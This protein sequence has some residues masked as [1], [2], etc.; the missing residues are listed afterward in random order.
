MKTKKT[1]VINDREYFIRKSDFTSNESP[2]HVSDKMTGKLSGI[3]SIS[4]ACL[5]N[6]ICKKRMENGN[7]ICAHCFAAALLEK[8]DTV[9]Q[10]M[11]S[12]FYLLQNLLP[13]D[14]LPRFRNVCIVRIES[15]GDVASVNQ[16]KN[17]INICKVNP[18]VRFAAWTKN[19]WIWEAAIDELGKPEN[20][21]MVFSSPMLNQHTTPKYPEIFNHIFTVYDGETIAFYE[22]GQ[23][24]INCGARDC[25]NCQKCYRKDTEFMIRE[26][27]K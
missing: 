26:R 8:K 1:I 12:N 6:P 17:Y 16:A 13:L 5:L 2:V 27:L 19:D 7:S 4:T 24:F 14:M 10:A 21:T 18:A 3:P 23:E 11:K 15:F 22:N 20:L 25:W 9:N